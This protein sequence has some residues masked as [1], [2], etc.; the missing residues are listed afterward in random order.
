MK[1]FY[2]R[3]L[4]AMLSTLGAAGLVAFADPA[5]AVGDGAA[6]HGV[7]MAAAAAPASIAHR[8]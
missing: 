1:S 6:H 8:G 7:G 3:L 2:T 4:C 5:N